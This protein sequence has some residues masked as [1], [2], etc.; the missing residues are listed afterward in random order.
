M[1]RKFIA[2]LAVSAAALIVIAMPAGAA[3][4]EATPVSTSQTVTV[5]GTSQT[6]TVSGTSQEIQESTSASSEVAGASSSI[7]VKPT[8]SVESTAAGA[9]SY[10]GVSFN[11]PLTL[12]IAAL[13]VL[14]G[15][16]LVFFGGRGLSRSRRQ[17]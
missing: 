1:I 13:V 7:T 9:L 15:F 17:H 10:T 11:V 4:T 8:S 2:A 14:G 12:A 3:T 6:V 16:A 5:S